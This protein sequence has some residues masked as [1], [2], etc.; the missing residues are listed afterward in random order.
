MKIKVT[1]EMYIDDQTPMIQGA[2]SEEDRLR[3]FKDELK[4]LNIQGPSTVPPPVFIATR[5][6]E[7]IK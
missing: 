5:I 6:E 1:V 7:V 2:G 3:F 4:K